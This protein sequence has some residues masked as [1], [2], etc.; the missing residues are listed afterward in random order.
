M[1]EIYMQRTRIGLSAGMIAAAIYFVGMLGGYVPAIILAGY[2]LLFEE[3]PWLR[4]S[5]VKAVATMLLFS[6][7]IEAINLIPDMIGFI[8]KL[9]RI[10]EGD[11]SIAVLDRIV[12]AVVSALRLIQTVLFITLGVKAFRQ[13]TV[14][15]PVVDNLIN[16]YMA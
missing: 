11:F 14:K 1:E 9:A 6:F 5:A 13:G 4:R 16:K 7:A 8:D 2:V 12:L 10:F 15:V 3:N